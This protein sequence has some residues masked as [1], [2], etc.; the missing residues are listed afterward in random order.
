MKIGYAR[1]STADQH[2]ENQIEKLE[3]AGCERIYT[4]T[5]SG[6]KW[7]RTE[8]QACLKHL[9]QGDVLIVWKLDRLS[10]SLRD[11]L[12]ILA[13]VDKGGATFKSLT[14]TIDTTGSCG[15]LMMSMLGAFAQFERDMIRERTKLGLARARKEG[16]VGGGQFV[17]SKERQA[18]AIRMVKSGEKTQTEV[19]KLFDV[20]K[21]NISRMMDRER[22]KEYKK[23]GLL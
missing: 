23:D 17:L 6:G 15:R 19:A 5:A 16:R 7:D 3:K 13:Q 21:A 4:E 20:S 2:A 10:R 8:L 1:V 11:L 14:E 18:E 9:R 12:Q 22:R